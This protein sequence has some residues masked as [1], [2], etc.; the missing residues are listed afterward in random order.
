M[1]C[2]FARDHL[3][4]PTGKNWH[5]LLSVH[6]SLLPVNPIEHNKNIPETGLQAV[7]LAVKAL[8][9]RWDFAYI[10]PCG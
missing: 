4:A 8:Q 9:S 10:L 1:F 2:N 5:T 3:P 7:L 6:I